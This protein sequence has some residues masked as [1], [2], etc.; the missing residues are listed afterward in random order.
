MFLLFP[1]IIFIF[2]KQIIKTTFI[3]ED[4][5]TNK[6]NKSK[7]QSN[8]FFNEIITDEYN[9]IKNDFLDLLIYFFDNVEYARG[10]TIIKKKY[11]D[12]MNKMNLRTKIKSIK[13]K[14]NK[15]ELNSHKDIDLIKIKKF[16]NNLLYNYNIKLKGDIDYKIILNE[17]LHIFEDFL[18]ILQELLNDYIDQ[19]KD[20]VETSKCFDLIVNKIIDDYLKKK[21]DLGS[22]IV[23]FGKT[24]LE[25]LINKNNY[26]N[27]NNCLQKS[28]TTSRLASEGN[29]LNI[30]PIY[31]YLLVIDELSYNKQLKYSTFFEKYFFSFGI[32]FIESG[33]IMDNKV[34]DKIDDNYFCGTND[35]VKIIT[36]IL[37]ILTDVNNITMEYFV[38]RDA[39][40]NTP[41][42]VIQLHLIP[43]YILI[44]PLFIRFLLFIFKRMIIKNKPKGIIY[45]LSSSSLSFDNKS[46][47]NERI[48]G[49]IDPELDMNNIKDNK[50]KIIPKWYRIITDI[51]SFEKN[52]KELFKFN[53]NNKSINNVLGLSYITSI[54]GI[55]MIFTIIGQT[56]FILFNSP[57][58]NFGVWN[59]YET[60]SKLSYIM[61]F[62]G[63][64]YS[65]RI[66]FS[67][68]GYTLSYKYLSFIRE[69]PKCY[70]ITFLLLESHKYFLL[71][72]VVFFVKYSFYHI[73]I[74][75][76]ENSPGWELFKMK[77]L[78]NQKTKWG[79][80]INF[81]TFKIQDI[82]IDHQRFNQD[83]F[84]YFWI[85]L[86]EVFFFIFGSIFISL[87]HS[88]KLKIDYIIIA[89][90]ILLYAGKII[91]Y[92]LYSEEMY[93][94]LYYYLFEYGKLMLNPIFNL[95]Y[96]LIGM[97]FGLIN[98][99]IQKGINEVNGFSDY[100]TILKIRET[101]KE[102]PQ[103]QNIT[104]IKYS[105]S[106]K[107]SERNS[108]N[109]FDD[110]LEEEICN[111]LKTGK[112]ELFDFD[113]N[114]YKKSSTSKHSKPKKNLLQNDNND[115]DNIF[116]IENIRKST[117]NIL[118]PIRQSNESIMSNQSL[119]EIKEM[120]FLNVPTNIV[121]FVRRTINSWVY[122][123]FLIFFTLIILIF[124]L[125]IYYFIY[126]Y[127]NIEKVDNN[128]NEKEYWEKLSLH[129]IITNKLLNI[130]YLID[131]EIVVLSVQLGFFFLYMKGQETING[132]FSHIYWSF[133]SKS[134]FSFIL[135]LS[136]VILFNFY[137]N[138]SVIKL[139]TFTIYLYSSI[140]LFIIFFVTILI[141]GYLE[142]PCKKIFKFCIRNYEIIDD[143]N[144]K[145]DENEDE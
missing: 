71:I 18:V 20:I 46:K 119:S 36:L 27:F 136:P 41:K 64:R 134:Y 94:T 142:L 45:S 111:E 7:I 97:Y 40:D 68:S 144:D 90:I 50:Q 104:N 53:L 37:D 138:D 99:S 22:L 57:I 116:D 4:T 65:P 93:T 16:L 84:D 82:K 1:F 2:L 100:S 29:P 59:F 89:L 44:I 105:K 79:T 60:I 32:C 38:L 140:N 51:F 130:L 14:K 49:S 56:Y 54:I 126:K 43:F 42:K 13:Q 113:N 123:F 69:K 131:I 35:Y 103:G 121:H 17:I 30:H 141:Y 3:N 83:L 108:I 102:E 67:C 28:E 143:Q 73:Q 48:S 33:I 9:K 47:S 107:S 88:L 115:E 109:F 118:K 86:N 124:I 96:F 61:I 8:G 95:S 92:Q 133:F 24:F 70:L 5:F 129:K 74:L 78:D 63:L 39:H 72:L 135:I 125:A 110:D 112:N 87:G 26:F 31:F 12:V 19:I 80:L 91:Y 21:K 128:N 76:S 101:D 114:T 81:L 66:I 23:Y 62:I 85:P 55:S 34:V 137:D 122:I 15:A 75:A 11:F 132:F 98:Y 120:P 127:S 106:N 10:E 139:N 58:K 117:D 6:I 145:E 52:S 77:I 25:F